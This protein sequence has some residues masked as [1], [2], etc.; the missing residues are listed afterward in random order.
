M[1][2]TM[3]NPGANPDNAPAPGISPPVAT[4]PGTNFELHP[5]KEY[6]TA[7]GFKMYLKPPPQE[8]G[9]ESEEPSQ[10]EIPKKVAIFVAHG[11]GQQ[12][13]FQTLDQIVRGLCREADKRSMNNAGN[14]SHGDANH[15]P[16]TPLKHSPEKVP[17]HSNLKKLKPKA[18][19]IKVDN[20]WLQRTKLFLPTSKENTDSDDIEVH[21][22]EGYWGPLTE[23]KITAKGVI[24]FLLGAGLN[25][26]KNGRRDFFRWLFDDYQKFNSP[27]RTPLYLILTLATVLALVAMNAAIAVVAAGRALLA[28]TPS[29]LSDGLFADLTTT[30]N[31]V[32]AAMLMFG[33]SLL[34][35]HKFRRKLLSQQRT[36]W[37][38]LWG[39]INIVLFTVLLFVTILSGLSLALLFYG[40]LK[41]SVADSQQLWPRIFPEGF[42][43]GFNFIVN[44]ILQW[45]VIVA[46]GLL[47]LGWGW[48]WELFRKIT[49]QTDND[50]SESWRTRRL[51]FVL[52]SL[53]ILAVTLIIAFWCVFSDIRAN[54]TLE[55]ALNGLAWPLLVAG[56]AF[57]RQLLV[58]YVGDVAIYIDPYKLDEFFQLRLQIR[59][60][61]EKVARTVYTMRRSGG[62]GPE[63]NH[64]CMVGHSLGSVVVYD[65]LNRL[66]NDDIAAGKVLNIVGRTPLLLTFGSPLDKTAFLFSLQRQHTYETREALAA[67]GQPLIQDYQHRPKH[68]VNIHSDWDI[69]SG[70]LDF[71]DPPLSQAAGKRNSKHVCN[72]IDPE[73]TT[74]L[75][76]HMEYWENDLLFKT[77]YDT[78]C[79]IAVACDEKKE[80]QPH[81]ST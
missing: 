40:H 80:A 9:R 15:P 34:G 13:P 78:I 27:I 10:E 18:E 59:E 53:L 17:E 75:A 63:Y 16:E 6:S 61:V 68:W 1:D 28:D 64:V 56:S 74:L 60:C 19:A 73:A 3:N 55:T 66:I 44:F 11:M 32:V 37:R 30:F 38:T 50:N 29:W 5:A 81:A 62:Y 7:R 23:G 51:L 46:G 79:E 22:Y 70:K 48:G 4:Q 57:A 2:K 45:G 35:A 24:G 65:V 12:I 41:L 47:V 69:I 8:G 33:A 58:Q 54:E 31:M 20:Q 43:S 39:R 42:V 14:K 25:G 76:A 77:L 21:I 36:R 71:Y 67:T 72:K 52:G 49:A 26:I